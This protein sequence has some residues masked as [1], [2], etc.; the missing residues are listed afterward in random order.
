M[1]TIKLKTIKLSE[2]KDWFFRELPGYYCVEVKKTGKVKKIWKDEKGCRCSDEI[3][4]N[5]FNNLSESEEIKLSLLYEQKLGIIISDKH[6]I[7]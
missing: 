1:E 3:A 2:A 4:E 7:K 6:P 5:V